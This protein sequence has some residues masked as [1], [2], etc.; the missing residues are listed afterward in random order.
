LCK[1]N[2]RTRSASDAAERARREPALEGRLAV[3]EAFL[4]GPDRLALLQ[5]PRQLL[6]DPAPLVAVD[7]IPQFSAL[8]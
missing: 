4:L 5:R 8:S 6:L 7:G 2:E 3:K 1:G